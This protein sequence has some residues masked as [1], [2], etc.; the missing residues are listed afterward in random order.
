MS[1][2]LFHDPALAGMLPGSLAAV[3]GCADTPGAAQ[4]DQT[5]APDTQPPPGGMAAHM[6]GM[7]F[8]GVG[9]GR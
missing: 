3:S 1:P 9:I 5:R 4:A 6:N 2:I 8:G 7:V